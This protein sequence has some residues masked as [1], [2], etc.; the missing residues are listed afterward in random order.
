MIIAIDFTG[1]NGT[2]TQPS[3]LHY[4]DRTKPNQYQSAIQAVAQILLNY[5]SDK[6]IPAF[7]FGADLR[8][9]KMH[10]LTHCFPLSGDFNDV[11]SVGLPHLM[12]L[13][14]QA[15]SN[16]QLSGPTYFGPIIDQVAKIA[17][18]CRNSQS[19][20]YQTLLILT[21]GEIHDMDK[22]IDLIIDCC[23]LPL[24]I[25]IVGVGNANFDNMDRLDGDGGLYGS[26]GQRAVRD[27]VQFV[28]FR[29][30]QYNAD[31]LAQQLLA[32]LPGQ[33]VQYFQSLGVQPRQPPPSVNMS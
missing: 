23:Q 17:S 18:E 3:S 16:L 7:G 27:I 12:Q 20:I 6:R 29:N 22:V 2:P 26:K 31:V 30:V 4:M 19:H 9:P 25:I 13:Y 1:S 28:P 21:D 10:G 14:Q 24:S 11:D 15:L 5:D 32:E 33:V 8:F